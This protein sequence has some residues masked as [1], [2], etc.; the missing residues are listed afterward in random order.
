MSIK[1][2][3]DGLTRLY[4]ERGYD[5]TKTRVCILLILFTFVVLCCLYLLCDQSRT[6]RC[7]AVLQLIV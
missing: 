4:D 1:T 6:L 3:T 5:G 7:V 2:T